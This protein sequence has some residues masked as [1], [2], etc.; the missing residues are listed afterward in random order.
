M[1]KLGRS[2]QD[3]VPHPLALSHAHVPGP[4]LTGL[5][6]GPAELYTAGLSAVASL[7]PSEGGALRWHTV[8]LHTQEE[9]V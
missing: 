6:A 8:I 7:A 2:P 4:F 3:T 9:M 1:P 5:A